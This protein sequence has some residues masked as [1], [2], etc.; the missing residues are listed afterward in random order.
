MLSILWILTFDINNIWMEK[1]WWRCPC[2]VCTFILCFHSF[3]F[4]FSVQ[5]CLWLHQSCFLLDPPILKLS[6]H[7][8]GQRL[9]DTLTVKAPCRKGSSRPIK[10]FHLMYW[11]K[12]DQC[13]TMYVLLLTPNK[14]LSQDSIKP[15]IHGFWDLA[16]TQS[17]ASHWVCSV[18]PLHKIYYYQ[19]HCVDGPW[20]LRFQSTFK[21]KYIFS[22]R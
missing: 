21:T 18:K 10:L 20:L 7:C 11:L 2:Q 1:S 22:R 16:G 3:N 12:L 5:D 19:Y 6:S 17:T 4:L 14:L 13:S 8:V 9:W 15:I